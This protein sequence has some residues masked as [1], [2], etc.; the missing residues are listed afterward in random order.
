[1]RLDTQARMYIRTSDQVSVA[2][3]DEDLSWSQPNLI[4][5]DFGERDLF[6]PSG[7][8]HYQVASQSLSDGSSRMTMARASELSTNHRLGRAGV[9]GCGTEKHSVG[10]TSHPTNAIRT[11]LQETHI[12][13]SSPK[14]S[15]SLRTRYETSLLASLSAPSPRA[16]QVLP[17]RT[18]SQPHTHEQVVR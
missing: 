18:C 8:Y 15:D 14:F 13:A 9:M 1:M 7:N 3:K 5:P 11:S 16:E 4:P 6:A 17:A 10:H 2:L 12:I